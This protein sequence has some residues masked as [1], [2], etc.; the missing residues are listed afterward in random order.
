MKLYLVSQVCNG[1]YDTYSDIVVA[2]LS[3]KDARMIDP[4]NAENTSIHKDNGAWCAPSCLKVEYL[5][6]TKHKRGVICDSFHAG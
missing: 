6:P 1:G 2:A 3:E 5:G 4:S